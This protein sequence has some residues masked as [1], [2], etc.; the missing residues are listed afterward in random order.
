[1]ARTK[2]L[3]VEDDL[4]LLGLMCKKL[5]AE[6]FEA[7]PIET[8]KAAFDYLQKQ[9]PDLVLLDILLPDIDGLTILSEIAKNVKLRD[10]PVIILS[11]LADQ[12]SFEQAGSIGNYEYL[13][14][15]KTDLNVV[16][17]KIKEKLRL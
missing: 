11:N 4:D 10:L 2:I 8:G 3:V 1:M 9:R 15:T 14:K 6:G 17:Q 5:T 16:V 7:I 13:V 12:G